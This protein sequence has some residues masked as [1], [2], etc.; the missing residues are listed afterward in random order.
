MMVVRWWTEQPN[1]FNLKNSLWVSKPEN[2][3][4]GKRNGVPSLASYT[5]FYFSL[6]LRYNMLSLD[7]LLDI[8]L[9]RSF[10]VTHIYPQYYTQMTICCHLLLYLAAH[11][12]AA[13]A[14]PWLMIN[15]LLA[16][17]TFF[18]VFYWSPPESLN[19][20]Q[21]HHFMLVEYKLIL[22]LNI[23]TPDAWWLTSASH[24]SN[25]ACPCLPTQLN[26]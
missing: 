26:L 23:L 19:F 16:P 2:Y 6:I 7:I 20:N 11:T 15:R 18:F 24:P 9:G 3:F 1:I 12:S 22:V 8:L 21:P 10:V 25:F 4:Q 17:L 13:G 5:V 14:C